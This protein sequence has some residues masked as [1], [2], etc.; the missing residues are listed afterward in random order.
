MLVTCEGP[1]FQ[2]GAGECEK[3]VSEGGEPS[4]ALGLEGS[5]TGGGG[6]GLYVGGGCR[7]PESRLPGTAPPTTRG[8]CAPAQSMCLLP[9]VSVHTHGFWFTFLLLKIHSVS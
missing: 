6:R 3:D 2:G 9:W 5:G 7:F 8:L 4:L 1:T